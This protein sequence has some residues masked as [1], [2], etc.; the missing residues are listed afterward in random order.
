[1][2]GTSLL[3]RGENSI[4]AGIFLVVI[5]VMPVTTDAPYLLINGLG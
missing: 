3:R 1:M 5:N 4:S 2:P